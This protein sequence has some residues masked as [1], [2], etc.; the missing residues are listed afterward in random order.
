M[1]FATCETTHNP[2]EESLWLSLFSVVSSSI[3][4]AGKNT[5]AETLAGVRSVVRASRKVAEVTAPVKGPSAA[6]TTT[7]ATPA[8][9]KKGG[10]PTKTTESRRAESVKSDAKC[11]TLYSVPVCQTGEWFNRHIAA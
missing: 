10:H 4:R 3:G 9:K 5:Y 7:K 1:P 2:A 6:T 11:K 8:V